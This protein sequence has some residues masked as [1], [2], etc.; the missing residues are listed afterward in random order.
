MKGA[1]CHCDQ[2]VKLLMLPILKRV[3]IVVQ[4][5]YKKL[6]SSFV[7]DELRMKCDKIAEREP[8]KSESLYK[9]ILLTI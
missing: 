1:K 3:K 7:Y 4:T 5:L 2:K 6:L 8:I 9:Y